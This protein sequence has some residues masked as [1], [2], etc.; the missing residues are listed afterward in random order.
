MILD[1]RVPI[2]EKEHM[3]YKPI[4]KHT[5]ES[6]WQFCNCETCQEKRFKLDNLPGKAINYKT[7]R[8]KDEDY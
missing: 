8:L 5:A 7:F 6:K 4:E 1:T 2:I 3:E